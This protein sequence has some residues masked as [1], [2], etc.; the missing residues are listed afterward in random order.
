MWLTMIRAA[1]VNALR[2]SP[3]P[4]VGCLYSWLRSIRMDFSAWAYPCLSGFR[5]YSKFCDFDIH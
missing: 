1:V 3:S 5:S 4:L 2:I